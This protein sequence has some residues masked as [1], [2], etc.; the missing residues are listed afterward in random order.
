MKK[1]IQLDPISRLEKILSL[2]RGAKGR[3][4][5]VKIEQLIPEKEMTTVTFYGKPIRK[6]Q[7]AGKQ[8]FVISDILSL[9][10][11][12]DISIDTV[13]YTDNFD[14]T[15]NK[16]IKIIDQLEVADA[17]GILTLIKEVI[18]IFPGPLARW[19]EGN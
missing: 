11:P 8:Y 15:K 5:S 12:T 7:V 18:G 6:Y 13:K 14:E 3:F 16:V 4:V 9:A 10:A 19:L 2:K 17:E 1:Q